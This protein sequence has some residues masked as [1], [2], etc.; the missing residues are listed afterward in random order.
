MYIFTCINKQMS[1]VE[2]I[3]KKAK[4][5]LLSTVIARPQGNGESLWRI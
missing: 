3:S 2:E 4:A 5:V 1:D